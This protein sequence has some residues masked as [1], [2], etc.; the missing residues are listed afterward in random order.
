MRMLGNIKMRTKI[1]IVF[2]AVGIIPFLAIGFISKVFTRNA[3]DA[4]VH[5]QLITVREMKKKEIQTYFDDVTKEMKIF[6]R[7]NGILELFN[8]LLSLD[9]SIS[10]PDTPYDTVAPEYQKITQQLGKNVINFCED[11]GFSDVYMICATHGHVMFSCSRQPD[12]GTSLNFGPYKDSG[13]AR[14]WKKIVKTGK[15]AV[16]DFEPYPPLNNKPVMFA[17][18]PVF[19]NNDAVT[20]VFAFEITVDPINAIM[21]ERDGMN[22]TEETYLVG[23]DRLMRSDSFLNPGRASVKGSFANPDTGKVDT[24]AVREALSGHSGEKQITSYDG[25]QVLSAYAPMRIDE[26]NWTILSETEKNEAYGVLDSLDWMMVIVTVLVILVITLLAFM[27]TRSITYPVNKSTRFAQRISEYD[28]T[29]LLDMN[30]DDEIGILSRA[31]NLM[32]TN[33]KKMIGQ[34]AEGVETLSASSTELS[35]IS[36]QMSANA[37]LTYDQSS[38]VAVSAE[39][40]SV[41]MASIAAAAEQASGNVN[42]VAAASE[43]MTATINEIAKSAEKARVMTNRA[44]SDAQGASETVH[45][46]GKAAHEIGKVTETIADISDQTNL[47]ALNATIEAARAGDAGRGFA[48]VANEIKD[49]AKQTAGATQEIKNK[50][51][52]IQETTSGTVARIQQIS[53]VINDINE[54]VSSIAA[55]VEEQSITTNDIAGSVLH[56]AQGIHEVTQNVAESSQVAQ[57]IAK[58]IT[59]V[60]HAAEEISVNST[61]VNMS[62]E[63]LRKLARDLKDM[64]D[65]FKM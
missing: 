47:L 39:Q 33:L 8:Q 58:D 14:L 62:A 10:Q 63:D 51:D 42:M 38:N 27:I 12:L 21:N 1:M 44:V 26:L 43:E 7:R 22:K 48:V 55:A 60:N 57:T 16:V 13:L 9:S 17:G 31:L 46:L 40:M 52:G 56:A 54:I 24:E 50:I 53:C 64:V 18:Y 5:R 29:E 3:L 2:L 36:R 4:Q 6:S 35:A 30:Q 25:R 15:P 23:P 45:N 20:G 34:I 37:S 41:S 28:F 19:G 11:S 61:Q 59:G 65:Q 49:L 32:V